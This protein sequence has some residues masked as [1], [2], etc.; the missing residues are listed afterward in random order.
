[1]AA[2]T[3]KASDVMNSVFIELERAI[4]KFPTWPTDPLHAIAVLG[5]EFGELTKDVLQMTYEPGKTNAENVRK[6]AIQTAAM[7]L[8]F[9]ASLDAYI[10]KAGEQHRQQEWQATRAAC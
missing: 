4:A 6:E 8:R 5:E 9:V 1:M 2:E 10:Y 3:V 7:A